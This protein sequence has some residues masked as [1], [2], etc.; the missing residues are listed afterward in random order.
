MDQKQQELYEG[1]QKFSQ[2]EKVDLIKTGLR[3]IGPPPRHQKDVVIVGAGMAG[4]VAA[5]ELKRTGRFTVKVLEAR[6]NVGGRI[7]TIREPYF[8]PGLYGEAGAMRLPKS[9]KLTLE[10]I[11]LAGTKRDKRNARK[12][13]LFNFKN[14]DKNAWCYLNGT[15]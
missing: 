5:Y 11:T 1:W 10:Y 15:P 8:S 3:S 14:D 6:Q 2:D 9:H 13:E 12:L 7:R 4:L